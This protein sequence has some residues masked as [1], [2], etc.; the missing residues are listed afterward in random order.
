MISNLQAHIAAHDLFL[1]SCNNERKLTPQQF[2]DSLQI[3]LNCKFETDL[4][5]CCHDAV[6]KKHLSL[7]VRKKEY[8]FS[9]EIIVKI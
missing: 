8:W 5:F 6:N 1:A 7:S 3:L 2:A 4:V 9:S